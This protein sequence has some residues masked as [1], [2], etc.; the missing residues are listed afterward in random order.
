[1]LS[2]TALAMMIVTTR[3]MARDVMELLH[4]FDMEHLFGCRPWLC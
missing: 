4:N 1:M 3:P 2:W